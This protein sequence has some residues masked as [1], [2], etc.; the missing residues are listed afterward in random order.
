MPENRMSSGSRSCGTCMDGQ[1]RLASKI[2]TSF[3][4]KKLRARSSEKLNLTPLQ[5][6]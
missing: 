6:I 5:E 4:S 1:V 3:E 2:L